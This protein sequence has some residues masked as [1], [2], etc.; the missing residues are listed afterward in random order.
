MK[1]N[2]SHVGIS[3]CGI[4]R[5]IFGLFP[6]AAV[7]EPLAA[8]LESKLPR[9]GAGVIKVLP[10]A[11]TTT[12]SQPIKPV[13][14]ANIGVDLMGTVWDIVGLFPRAAVR[15]P[16]AAGLESKLPREGAGVI[17]VSPVATTVTIA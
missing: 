4:N 9:E 5:D 8:G 6:R 1:A 7:C 17:K 11:I 2:P 14:P 3:L 10:V 15:E 16:L 13:N 12:N